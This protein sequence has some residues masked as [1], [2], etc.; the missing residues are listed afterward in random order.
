MLIT[1]MFIRKIENR[2]KIVLGKSYEDRT[3]KKF[4]LTR[5]LISIYQ[6]D[7]NLFKVTNGNTRTIWEIC[8]KIKIKTPGQRHWRRSGV[9]FVN[10]EQIS[11]IVLVFLLW[12]WTSKYRQAKSL[13]KTKTDRSRRPEVLCK[14]GVLQNFATLVS[15][16][17]KYS[18]KMN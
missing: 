3:W 18:C 7:N 8:S 10:F 4:N 1:N 12:L 15:E 14:K 17:L 2:T 11:R 5:K 13:Q 6:A 16:T 9:F